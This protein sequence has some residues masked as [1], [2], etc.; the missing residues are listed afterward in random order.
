MKERVE[1]K[2]AVFKGKEVR[3]TIHKNEWW[4]SIVDVIAVLTDSDNPRNYWSM[5]KVR[6]KQQSQIQLSTLCV[7]LKQMLK[8]K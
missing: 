1:T 8:G 6:E 5:M 2:I 7:Q 4:F 3:K